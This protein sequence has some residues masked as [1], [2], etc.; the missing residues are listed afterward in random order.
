MWRVW[1]GMWYLFATPLLDS[2]LC[3]NSHPRARPMAKSKSTKSADDDDTYV[4]SQCVISLSD[5]THLCSIDISSGD[6]AMSVKSS[7]STKRY[8]F[9]VLSVFLLDLLMSNQCNV[10]WWRGMGYHPSPPKVSLLLLVDS[11]NIW[12]SCNSRSIVPKTPVSS[13][14][15][16]M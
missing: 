6:D 2:T 5:I 11:S 14:T 4:M 9:F 10:D 8:C 3:T 16:S 12:Y 15:S 1:P 13:R 7:K